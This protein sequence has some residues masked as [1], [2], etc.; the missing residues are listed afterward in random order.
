M[1]YSSDVN[2]YYLGM[3]NIHMYS[4]RYHYTLTSMIDGSH[5]VSGVLSW[6]YTHILIEISLHTNQYD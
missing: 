3:N 1:S 6:Q 4:L 5:D 2:W